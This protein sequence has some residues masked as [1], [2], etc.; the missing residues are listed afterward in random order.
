MKKEWNAP[1]LE[2]LDINMTMQGDHGSVAD[3]TVKEPNGDEVFVT[4]G[5]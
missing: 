3:G 5:S 2:E 1:M 4:H